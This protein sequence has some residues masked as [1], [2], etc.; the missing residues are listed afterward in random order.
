LC[1][2]S[3]NMREELVF[4]SMNLSAVRNQRVVLMNAESSRSILFLSDLYVL[5][6]SI[7]SKGVSNGFVNA[8]S[9]TM[10][11]GELAQAIADTWGVEVQDKGDSSTYSFRLNNAKMLA[12]C[13]QELEQLD[14]SQRC[15]QFVAEYE[16]Y[17]GL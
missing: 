5:I 1:G 9:H 13:G 17:R 11:M 4:N 8:C 3:D 6:R 7:L 2:Y 10:K 16:R 14:L 12:L 15:R